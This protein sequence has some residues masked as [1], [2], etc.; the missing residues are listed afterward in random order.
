MI[1]TA[2]DG[3]AVTIELPVLWGDQDSFGHVNNVAYLRWFETARVDYLIR[4][5]QFP[6]LPP[7]GIGPILAS[8]TCNYRT[9]LNYP[10]TVRIGTRVTEIGNSSYRMEHRMVSVALSKI[11]ADAVSVMVLLDYGK[12]QTVR[13]PDETRRVI[14]KIEGKI[15]A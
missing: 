4:V 8:L 13:V 15:F 12:G 1:E 11:A 14:G 10:D 6:S 5:E 7:S 2:L 9:P 3:Y